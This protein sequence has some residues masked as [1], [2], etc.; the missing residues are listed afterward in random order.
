VPES[1]SAQQQD[2]AP[3]DVKSKQVSRIDNVMD[4]RKACEDGMKNASRLADALVNL[5][6]H[7]VWL[8]G[9]SSETSDENREFGAGRTAKVC[10]SLFKIG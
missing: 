2:V 3:D 1:S 7:D 4:L 6:V 5:T 10:S 8:D 9:A